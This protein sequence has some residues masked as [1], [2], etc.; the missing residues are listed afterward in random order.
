M[1]TAHIF[2]ICLYLLSAVQV[3]KIGMYEARLGLSRRP[4][5]RLKLFA[6]F[7]TFKQPKRRMK[8]ATQ[9][10]T[11]STDA[12]AEKERFFKRT[13]PIRLILTFDNE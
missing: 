2:R 7:S 8:K 4:K 5:T 1:S 12:N 6:H 13:E 3:E 10:C 11:F 9:S